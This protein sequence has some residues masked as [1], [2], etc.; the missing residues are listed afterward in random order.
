MPAGPITSQP[1]G[2]TPQARASYAPRTR[3]ALGAQDLSVHDTLAKYSLAYA[4]RCHSISSLG[5]LSIERPS[6]ADFRI[7]LGF[8][9][10]SNHHRSPQAVKNVMDHIVARS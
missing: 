2:T 3:S 5:I 10:C 8:T 4:I 9:A 7:F 6:S 1:T